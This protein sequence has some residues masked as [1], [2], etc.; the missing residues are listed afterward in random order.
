[1]LGHTKGVMAVCVSPSR[2]HIITSSDDRTVIVWDL[3]RCAL[4]RL[5]RLN[6]GISFVYSRSLV[7]QFE[8]HEDVARAVCVSC[9]GARIISASNDGTI[10]VWLTHDGTLERKYDGHDGWVRL[11]PR[12]RILDPF[13]AC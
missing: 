6:V 7:R 8:G 12:I 10:C 13:H 4:L 5:H 3:E 11:V 1:M 9:D 2:E